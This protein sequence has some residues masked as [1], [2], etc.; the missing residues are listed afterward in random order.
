[1]AIWTTAVPAAHLYAG[2]P[3]MRT[4]PTLSINGH[5]LSNELAGTYTHFAAGRTQPCE[6]PTCD[7]C[8][9]KVPYRYHAYL[10]ILLDRTQKAIILELTAPPAKLVQQF[11]EAN[12]HIRGAHIIASRPRKTANGRI[13]IYMSMGTIPPIDLPPAIDCT[14]FMSQL[15]NIAQTRLNANRNADGKPTLQVEPEQDVLPIVGMPKSLRDILQY[16][17]TGGNGRGKS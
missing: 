14:H 4:P 1:M 7:H 2:I 11:Q 17:P 12:G 13:S 10:A 15:W 5:I 9:A 16:Q 8:E 6:A 3:L